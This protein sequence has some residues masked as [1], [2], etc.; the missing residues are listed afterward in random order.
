MRAYNVSIAFL[1]VINTLLEILLL[2]CK[3][4]D[5]FQIV[6]NDYFSLNW[7]CNRLILS[8]FNFFKPTKMKSPILYNLPSVQ[9]EK[10]R[11][12]KIPALSFI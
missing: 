2:Q 3:K 12:K 10:K 5:T 8:P 6:N 9:Y 7:Y 1:I 4:E 11:K